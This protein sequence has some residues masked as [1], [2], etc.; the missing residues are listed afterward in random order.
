MI[1]WSQVTVEEADLAV[2]TVLGEALPAPADA[3]LSR[4]SSGA[5]P[6]ADHLIPRSR[7]AEAV[8]ELEAASGTLVG[9]M[10]FTAERDARVGT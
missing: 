1:F 3:V 10:A 4:R 9:L 2:V 7:L 8:A 6:I 5:G